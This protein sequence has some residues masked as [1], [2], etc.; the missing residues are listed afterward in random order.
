MNN[1]QVGLIAILAMAAIFLMVIVNLQ[2]GPFQQSFQN[3]AGFAGFQQ[4]NEQQQTSS[5]CQDS[6]GLNFF[7]GGVVAILSRD[8][9]PF[10]ERVFAQYED[11]CFGNTLQE[12]F[13]DGERAVSQQYNCRNGCGQGRCL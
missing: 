2:T 11:A 5:F 6:D 12:Y 13:C 10:G 9:A 3:Q 4:V 8:T 7:Q 1:K